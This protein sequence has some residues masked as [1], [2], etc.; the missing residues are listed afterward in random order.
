MT[1]ERRDRGHRVAHSEKTVLRE[2]AVVTQAGGD[3]FRSIS[4][5][6]HFHPRCQCREPG[7]MQR[8]EK[9]ASARLAANEFAGE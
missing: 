2:L 8:A 7:A 6:G 4:H 1:G 9:Q 5:L 3:H